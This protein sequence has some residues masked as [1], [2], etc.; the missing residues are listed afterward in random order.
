MHELTLARDIV[1]AVERSLPR[2]DAQVVRV[3]VSIGSAS[4]IV[5][6]SLRLAFET[7]AGTRLADAELGITT[8]AARSRCVACGIVFDFDDLI[9]RCCACGR[10]GGELLSGNEVILRTI[11]VADV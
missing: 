7:V 11:E 6:E 8:I 5:S 10:L 3:N 2:G 4:G 9:G 1:A